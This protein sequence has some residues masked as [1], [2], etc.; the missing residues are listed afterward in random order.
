MSNSQTIETSPETDFLDKAMYEVWKA[1]PA[2]AKTKQ[3]HLA[4]YVPIDELMEVL[5][6]LLVEN[7]LYVRQPEIGEGGLVGVCTMVT[8]IP[9]GQWIRSY[10]L[11][12]N[13][14]PWNKALNPPQAT[15]A[16]ISYHARIALARV[17]G[18]LTV[19][20]DAELLEP[21]WATGATTGATTP[22]KK[23]R[24]YDKETLV[25]AMQTMTESLQKTNAP[26][27]TVEDVLILAGDYVANSGQKIIQIVFNTADPN[28]YQCGAL[29]GWL[30]GG[31]S[32]EEKRKYIISEIKSLGIA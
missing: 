24:P 18:I 8:H 6:P 7:N 10:A 32:D 31:K 11:M 19:E 16:I 27:A 2:L 1:Q 14:E 5:G 29:M 17:F 4:K 12:P 23:L 21:S 13:A 28:Q 3:G 22:T 20:K 26:G 25:K 9:S 30:S 15:G